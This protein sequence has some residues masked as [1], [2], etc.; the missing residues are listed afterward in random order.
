VLA[1]K[2]RQISVFVANRAGRLASVTHVLRD[3]GISIRA[4]SMADAPDFGI[5]RLVVRDVDRA[6]KALRGQGF[7]VDVTDVVAVEVPDRPGGL[8]AVLDVLS[9]MSVN[10][11][12]MYAFLTE[13]EG[14]ALIFFRF[15][16]TDAALDTLHRAGIPVVSGDALWALADRRGDSTESRA[17]EPTR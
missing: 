16:D 12:Y 11:E 1:V 13:R 5:F 4:L 2:T 9:S 10:V 15:E 17:G 3:E 6:V 8:A 14:H 7:I